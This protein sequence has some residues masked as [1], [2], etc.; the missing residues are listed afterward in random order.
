[1]ATRIP[2]NRAPFTLAEV[3]AI[4]GGKLFG[5]DRD[6][7][8]VI[9]DSRRADG[10]NLFV[11]LRGER[12]DAHRFVDGLVGKVAG[13]VVETS[14]E[15][16]MPHV[17][18]ED[19]AVALR[20]LAAAHRRRWAKTVVAITGSAGKTSTKELTAS[21]LRG[22]GLRVLAT[23]GNLNNLIGAP[24]TLFGLAEEHDV[25]IIELGTSAPG[26]IPAL[27]EMV[28][29][30]VA[31][32]TLVAVSHTEGMGGIEGVYREKTA[33]LEGAKVRWVNGFD[34]RLAAHPDEG[35]R[36]YGAS[37][38][39]KQDV[40]LRGWQ[41]EGSG[42]C[43][44]YELGGERHR[45]CLKLLGEAAALN[46]AGA[47]AVVETLRSDFGLGLSFEGALR[48]LEAL[49]PVAGR[50]APFVARGV[51]VLD[52]SYNANPS[53]MA[54]ALHTASALGGQGRLVAMLGDM[55]EL[56]DCAED[57]HREVVGLARELGFS[58]L[59]LGDEMHR[60]GQGTENVA[61]VEEALQRLGE[62][63]SG[64]VILIKGSRF[65]GLEQA[66]DA[67]RR[68]METPSGEG[69]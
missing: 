21:A 40:A 3:A 67:L 62:L 27:A 11:A 15:T 41:F 17:L 22:A 14:P 53:S 47:L 57:K 1:M 6:C 32:V 45:V 5:E 52:D 60:Q 50:M 35:L 25:A 28:Q 20:A 37:R 34:Q 43:A 26:E 38:E 48:G 16:E 10:T 36:F 69:A 4:T 24:M 46:A 19:T 9:T 33:L 63:R 49:A 59:L 31:V 23:D 54:L 55:G 58:L 7:I 29:A 66:A 30:D 64:D 13:A 39:G 2:D 65:M 8:G 68:A 12:F 51:T 56:G 61:T 18:V 44:D 42:T